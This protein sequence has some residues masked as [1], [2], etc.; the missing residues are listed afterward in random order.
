MTSVF[1]ISFC[2]LVTRFP[3]SEYAFYF[4]YTV[5]ALA[6]LNFD[7]RWRNTGFFCLFS[8]SIPRLVSTHMVRRNM[9]VAGPF[10]S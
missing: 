2:G 8:V 9:G 7:T 1:A 5:I 3:Q 10:P 6:S 4:L